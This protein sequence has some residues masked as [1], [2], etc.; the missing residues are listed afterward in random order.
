M[1]STTVFK[2]SDPR[3]AKSPWC[4]RWVEY[5]DGKAKR[6]EAHFPTKAEAEDK[7][8]MV[9]GNQKVG[10]K[11]YS[12]LE[13]REIDHAL[14]LCRQ[15][16]VG[17][18]DVVRSGLESMSVVLGDRKKVPTV[19]WAVESFYADGERRQLRPAALKNRRTL[20]EPFKI[21][22]EDRLVSTITTDEILAYIVA[23]YSHEESRKT[24]K[25]G[26]SAW[27]NYCAAKG[28]E[29][30]PPMPPKALTWNSSIADKKRPMVYTADQV[31]MLLSK[32]QDKLKPAVAIACFAGVRPEELRRLQ[33]SWTD[34]HG[35][36]FG[37]DLRKRK[38]E[39]S[40]E[41]TKTRE[42][43]TLHDLPDNLWAWL[44][45]YQGKG[46]LVP[47]TQ[48]N[49]Y[50]NIN[51]AKTDAK[52]RKKGNDIM[53]HTF[54]SHGRHRGLDWVIEVLGHT[55]GMDVFRKHYCNNSVGPADAEKYFSIVP[56]DCR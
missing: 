15:H 43:R 18:L 42:P 1:A 33:W 32:V 49:W 46:M 17:L 51:K 8:S 50:R 47:I 27:Y 21:G 35:D 36:W 13:Y 29:W 12:D 34:P 30:V 44:E 16:E 31:E 37:I 5:V 24:L 20:L 40:G 14:E 53:R 26:L 22:R 54:G 45:K 4:C 28:R 23:K 48:R 41:W 56:G 39:L 38:I 6:R 10:R 25:G 11:S 2:K 3:R 52:I 7:A 9:N 55:E 19:E